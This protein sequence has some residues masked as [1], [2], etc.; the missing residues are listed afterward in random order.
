ME[1]VADWG[2]KK[3]LSKE[4]EDKGSFEYKKRTEGGLN[5]KT[6]T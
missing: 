6:Q 4:L 2:G 5:P 3:R 1:T